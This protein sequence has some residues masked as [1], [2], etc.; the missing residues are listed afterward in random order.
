M[1]KGLEERPRGIMII[2]FRESAVLRNALTF[3]PT[4]VTRYYP[5]S[6]YLIHINGK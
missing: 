5:T 6:L 1:V 3:D 4:A 2:H